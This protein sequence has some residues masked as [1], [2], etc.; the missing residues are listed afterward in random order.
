MAQKDRFFHLVR[1]HPCITGALQHVA[2][3][4]HKWTQ[5]QTQTQ[6]HK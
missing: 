5:T 1:K 2:T 6:T 3:Q 4:T